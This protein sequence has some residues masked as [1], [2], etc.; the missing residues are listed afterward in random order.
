MNGKPFY[1]RQLAPFEHR[2]Q[3]LFGL[4]SLRSPTGKGAATATAASS[5]PCSGFL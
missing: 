2:R 3:V 1:E 4:L 5:D